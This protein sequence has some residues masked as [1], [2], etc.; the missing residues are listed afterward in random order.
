MASI[1]NIK[2]KMLQQ[3]VKSTL[4][5]NSPDKVAEEKACCFGSAGCYHFDLFGS[6]LGVSGRWW[7]LAPFSAL[8]PLTFRRLVAGPLARE[9]R[10]VLTLATMGVR[11]VCRPLA[12]DDLWP[13]LCRLWC[14]RSLPDITVVAQ[15]WFR[16]PLPTTVA[17]LPLTIEGSW[18]WPGLSLRFGW[19]VVNCCYTGLVGVCVA[20][21]A[22]KLL[23][24][25]LAIEL[26]ICGTGGTDLSY[27]LLD[28]D[29]DG[30]VPDKSNIDGS[31][32]GCNNEL[33][34]LFW[35]CVDDGDGEAGAVFIDK[36]IGLAVDME[37]FVV[38]AA[39][40]LVNELKE[41]E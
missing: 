40:Q 10:V 8:V 26:Y 7:A 41:V 15:Q 12:A 33:V 5:N 4:N 1:D 19:V 32:K 22:V 9:V 24:I 39:G 27:K 36:V 13:L 35:V 20:D 23:A 34:G 6:D 38:A 14:A 37:D 3:V 30:D 28:D 25:E 21:A 29:G 18:F 11:L 2:A 31:P 17:I 16:K